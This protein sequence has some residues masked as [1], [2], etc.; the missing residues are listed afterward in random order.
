MNLK[1]QLK[2]FTGTNKYHK[3]HDL[4]LTEGVAFLFKKAG[5]H[6]LGTM[7]WS[8]QGRF[9]EELFVAHYLMVEDNEATY[10]ATDGNGKVLTYQHIGFTDFPLEEIKLYQQDKVLMLPGEY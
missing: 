7:I 1:E 4:L 5:S 8:H 2:H 6:W 10:Y 3:F 9:K